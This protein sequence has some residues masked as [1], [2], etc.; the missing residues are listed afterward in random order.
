MTVLRRSGA[1]IV[2]ACLAFAAAGT[3][4]AA[5]QLKATTTAAARADATK[6]IPLDKI[7]PTARKTVSEVI[8]KAGIFRRMPIAVAPC[9]PTLYRFMVRHPEVIVNIWDVMGVAKVTM[10]PMG[11]GTYRAAD[12]AGTLC[13]VQFV[14]SEGDTHVIFA[15]GA[16]TGPFFVKPVKAKC[17]LLLKSGFVRETNGAHYVTS[18][19][20]S[21][22]HVEN[23]GIDLVA[24]TVHPL[25]GRAADH[26][27]SET[28]AFLSCLSRSAQRN[29]PGVQR[30]AMK[31]NK[32][33]PG[34]RDEFSKIVAAIPPVPVERTVVTDRAPAPASRMK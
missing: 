27:F 22:I 6:A 15:D 4:C 3:L 28:A 2:V 9:D 26:N 1:F 5:E 20:D 17:V 10:Q 12:G 7:D 21:F 32:I 19:M 33:D 23:A 34:T 16:Y 31:L 18:R 8:A 11:P 13:D 25:V 30:L 14:Y 24:R 29:Q